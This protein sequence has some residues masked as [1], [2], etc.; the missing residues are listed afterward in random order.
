MTTVVTTTTTNSIEQYLGAR[1][2]YLLSLRNPKIPR[3][4]LNLPGPDV[5][6]RIY[7]PPDRN[8][9]NGAHRSD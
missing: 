7:T 1:A 3:S 4:R 5:V 2:E 6:D 8:S 9:Q